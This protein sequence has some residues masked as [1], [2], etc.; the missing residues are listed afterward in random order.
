MMVQGVLSHRR[1]IEFSY[2]GGG[3]T[4][5]Q[6]IMNAAYAGRQLTLTAVELSMDDAISHRANNDD[7]KLDSCSVH[8]TLKCDRT[9]KDIYGKG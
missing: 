3:M 5:W 1:V 2:F 9:V 6:K 4:P 7:L 8:G